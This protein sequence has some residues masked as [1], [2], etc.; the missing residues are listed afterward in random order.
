MRIVELKFKKMLNEFE[1]TLEENNPFCDKR[2]EN[3][4][5]WLKK[6]FIHQFID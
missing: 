2:S 5:L 4:D 3:Y 1:T 6:K